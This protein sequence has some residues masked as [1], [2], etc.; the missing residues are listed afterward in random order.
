L[1]ILVASSNVQLEFWPGMPVPQI[2]PSLC[3]WIW[4]T[5]MVDVNFKVSLFSQ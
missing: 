3:S 1:H 5:T 2:L 4:C